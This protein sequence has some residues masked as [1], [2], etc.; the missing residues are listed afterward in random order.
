MIATILFQGQSLVEMRSNMYILSPRCRLPLLSITIR[1]TE[2]I[3][4]HNP[5][6]T[7]A[8]L[9][10]KTAKYTCRPH[11]DLWNV[12]K[13]KSLG[14]RNLKISF[15]LFLATFNTLI[16]G[17]VFIQKMSTV[18]DD[19]LI[20]INISNKL[21]K[22]TFPV[23]QPFPVKAQPSVSLEESWF[24][25]HFRPSDYNDDKRERVTAH[26]SPRNGSNKRKL[27]GMRLAILLSKNNKEG[28]LN[29]G[30]FLRKLSTQHLQVKK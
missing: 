22:C 1:G 12:K 10:Q 25:A 15:V 7:S 19:Q 2:N 26:E 30:S 23:V 5:R 14:Y 16:L 4:H 3:F 24:I 11:T 28:F 21:N 17:D 29:V 9:H 18:Q 8:A 20:Q 13:S 27:E 6:K